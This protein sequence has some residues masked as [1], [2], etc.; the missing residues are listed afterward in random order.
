MLKLTKTGLPKTGTAAGNTPQILQAL[1]ETLSGLETL[2]LRVLMFIQFLRVSIL[3]Q[4]NQTLTGMIVG[5]MI[6]TKMNCS[7][8][9]ETI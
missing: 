7:A 4:G 1:I 8:D 5:K 9:Q 3:T 6:H 2:W